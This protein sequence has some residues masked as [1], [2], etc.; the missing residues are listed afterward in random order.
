MRKFRHYKGGEYEYIC[1]ARHSETEEVYIVYRPLYKDS[2]F[3]VRPKEMF[4]EEVRVN[5]V[6]MPR[7]AEIAEAE[8]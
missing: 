3:W 5:G 1:E 7:F 8:E 4:F 2:G 6:S